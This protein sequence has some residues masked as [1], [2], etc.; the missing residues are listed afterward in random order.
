MDS[1]VGFPIYDSNLRVFYSTI[2]QVQTSK[3]KYKTI[4]NKI[5]RVKLSMLVLPTKSLC[6][7]QPVDKISRMEFSMFILPAKLLF[8][9]F[10]LTKRSRAQHALLWE[11]KRRTLDFSELVLLFIF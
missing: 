9:V 4:Q 2:K 3:K 5:F 10:Q 6:G 1:F 11:Q 8:A 7:V